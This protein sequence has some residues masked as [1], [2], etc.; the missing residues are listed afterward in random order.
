MSE[1]NEREAVILASICY[2]EIYK[3]TVL[4]SIRDTDVT[5]T[6]LE[7]MAV[8]SIDGPQCMSEIS[9]KLYVKR[10][11][12]TRSVKSLKEMGLVTTKRGNRDGRRTIAVLAP[13]GLEFISKSRSISEPLLDGFIEQ[14]PVKDQKALIDCS[15]KVVEIFKRSGNLPG[16]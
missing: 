11:Q 1:N 5:K 2:A 8:L 16:I 6:Q 10:E 12:V 14:L 4:A 3:K 9:D 13:E 15:G 7:I